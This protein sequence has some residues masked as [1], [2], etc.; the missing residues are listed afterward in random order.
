MKLNYVSKLE[1]LHRLY[2]S[3]TSDKLRS[4]GLIGQEVT[5]IKMTIILS[6]KATLMVEDKKRFHILLENYLT[7]GQMIL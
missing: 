5:W 6:F 1:H 4:W 7:F 2:S 3:K